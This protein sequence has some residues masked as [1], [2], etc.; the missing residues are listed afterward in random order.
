MNG[1]LST[2]ITCRSNNFKD[3]KTCDI[4]YLCVC[5]SS[6]WQMK[7][8]HT[9]RL[10]KLT[11]GTKCNLRVKVCTVSVIRTPSLD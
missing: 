9:L 6:H 11:G 7:Y 2:V 10:V 1:F 5:F 8:G 4:K 3:L